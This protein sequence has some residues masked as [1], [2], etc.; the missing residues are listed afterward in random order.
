VWLLTAGELPEYEIRGFLAVSPQ[1]FMQPGGM[2][3]VRWMVEPGAEYD[4]VK[5]NDV[6]V[7]NSGEAEFY[8]GVGMRYVLEVQKGASAGRIIKNIWLW[9]NPVSPPTMIEIEMGPVVTRHNVSGED[10]LYT[11]VGMEIEM[12][13]LPVRNDVIQGE[14]L[15]TGVGMEIEMSRLP[16]RNDV[17]QGETLYTGVGMEIEMSRLPVRNDVIQGETL[18]TGVGMEIDMGPVPFRHN[19]GEA[20]LLYTGVEME[21]EIN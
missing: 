6:D 3:T 2:V 10:R 11:G 12:S 17:I 8:Q 7:P 21:I 4:S 1:F 13:R 5:I 14:T 15:Y 18:Y 16:V 9:E 19:I 20:E